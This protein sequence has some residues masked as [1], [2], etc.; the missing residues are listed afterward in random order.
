MD[1]TGE[2]D[3]NW[4]QCGKA[5]STGICQLCSEPSCMEFTYAPAKRYK[6]PSFRPIHIQYYTK[7]IIKVSLDM[8]LNVLYDKVTIFN[9]RGLKDK[10]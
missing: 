6:P 5:V 3:S 2:G 9:G 10:G 4:S 8:R 1:F 7:V